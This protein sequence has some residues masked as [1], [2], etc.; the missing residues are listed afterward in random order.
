[1]PKLLRL[2]QCRLADGRTFGLV[3][4]QDALTGAPTGDYLFGILRGDMDH[5]AMDIL[6][7]V[8]T[9][10]ARSL[11]TALHEALAVAFEDYEK[12]GGC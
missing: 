6:L 5:A 2:Y 8:R 12:T 10:E 7:R 3:R 1:M 4:D 9:R 11:L